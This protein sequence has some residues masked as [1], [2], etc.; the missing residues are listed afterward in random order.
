MGAVV[1]ARARYGVLSK[2]QAERL[3]SRKLRCSSEVNP[4]G[5]YFSAW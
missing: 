1:E 4:A 2:N 5:V 3:S